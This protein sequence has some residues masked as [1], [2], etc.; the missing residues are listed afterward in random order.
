MSDSVDLQERAFVVPS[1]QVGAA[2]P[3]ISLVVSRV[4]NFPYTLDEI[5]TELEERRAQAWGIREGDEIRCVLITRVESTPSRTYGLVWLTA[6]SGI[7]EGL[8]LF[9]EYIEP[10]FFEEK[11]CQWIELV[12]RKGWSK[13][14]PE[15]EEA[16]VRL[17]KYGRK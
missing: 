13:I 16:G 7:L 6:G 15:Y 12:G 1:Y 2:W 8:R 3:S 14:L 10:W 9:R 4:T 11:G 5:R 17:V